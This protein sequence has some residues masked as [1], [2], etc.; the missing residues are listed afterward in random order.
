MA[1]NEASAITVNFHFN[2]C[3]TCEKVKGGGGILFK[4]WMIFNI[5]CIL[6]TSVNQ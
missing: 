4:Y 6:S 2:G 3:T 1:R 5:E